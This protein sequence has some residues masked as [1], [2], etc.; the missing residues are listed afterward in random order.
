[1]RK[2]KASSDIPKSNISDSK[3]LVKGGK[4][5]RPAVKRK[6]ATV[7]LAPATAPATTP[8]TAVGTAASTA[9]NQKMPKQNVLGDISSNLFT[10]SNDEDEE[11]RLTV[12]TMGK[13][14]QLSVFKDAVEDSPG[15]ALFIIVSIIE[16]NGHQGR[17]ESPLEDH[18][19]DGQ[20]LNPVVEDAVMINVHQI[21][22]FSRSSP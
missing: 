11:F 12:E 17:T 15:K 4:Q 19:Y 6:A 10:P 5:K 7:A 3:N 18:R 16:A 2:S 9:L 13:K 22:F 20:C 21:R 14:R 8:D 1:M